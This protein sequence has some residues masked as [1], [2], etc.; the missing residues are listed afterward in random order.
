MRLRKYDIGV[1][2]KNGKLKV[3]IQSPFNPYL[4][5]LYL[6]IFVLWWIWIY[7]EIYYLGGTLFFSP[8]IAVL[9][10]IPGVY[11]LSRVFWILFGRD[12]FLIDK[13][14]LEIEKKALFIVYN[15]RYSL[16]EIRNFRML[17]EEGNFIKK[18]NN[19]YGISFFG[20]E[21][22]AYAFEYLGRTK[23]FGSNINQDEALF[24]FKQIKA[25]LP[26]S[27]KKK[28]TVEELESIP[29]HLIR[30]AG[31]LTAIVIFTLSIYVAGLDI[32][33]LR[34]DARNTAQNRII[35]FIQKKAQDSLEAAAVNLQNQNEN[36]YAEEQKRK[37]EMLASVMKEKFALTAEYSAL[38]VP[39]EGVKTTAMAVPSTEYDRLIF[40]MELFEREAAK[41]PTE[42]VRKLFLKGVMFCT[43][44]VVNGNPAA[45]SF[46]DSILFF[47]VR[48]YYMDVSVFKSEVHRQ[49]Y[50]AIKQR[51]GGAGVD[52]DG[53]WRKYNRMDFRYDTAYRL[54]KPMF[55]Y[56]EK[57][58]IS[59]SSYTSL[60]YDQ[61]DIF[62]SIFIEEYR[63]KLFEKIKDDDILRN[64][65]ERLKLFLSEFCT[66]MNTEYF[67][68]I[69]GLR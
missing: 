65:Y 3:T 18:S 12:R 29:I 22:C 4:L 54:Q 67:L 68:N 15:K 38:R 20:I 7:S 50:R 23:V 6:L 33:T 52:M 41:Y 14:V 55:E 36:T 69:Y 51:A 62:A 27:A 63:R 37:V 9:I 48:A 61:A 34:S 59:S 49:F 32:K 19:P 47:D 28:K 11:I 21:K 1:K 66:A 39:D 44:L 10:G 56:P 57:G 45:G 60:E 30:K 5:L 64:K 40:S 46:E 24:L 58:F 16:S 17:S 43:Y 2:E 53:F 42:L 31:A 13:D 35:P 8:Y 25:K 26:S